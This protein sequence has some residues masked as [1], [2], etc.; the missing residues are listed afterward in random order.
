LTDL[1]ERVGLTLTEM[2]ARCGVAG[3]QGRKTVGDWEAGRATPRASRRAK[4]VDYL[5]YDLQLREDP[6]RFDEVWTILVEEWGWEPLNATERMQLLDAPTSAPLTITNV[7]V[8]TATA[9]PVIVTPEP[10]APPSDLLADPPLPEITL[11]AVVQPTGFPWLA[12]LATWRCW[13]LI[14]ILLLLLLVGCQVWWGREEARLPPL[15]ATEVIPS[16][17]APL[18]KVASEVLLTSTVTVAV[19]S[20]LLTNG[21]F[22]QSSNFTGW[23]L[24]E[25]CDYQITAEPTLAQS[26]DHYLTIRNRRPRC[27]SFY[28]DV[29]TRLEVGVTYRASIWLRSATGNVRR[30]RLALWALG[31]DREHQETSFAVS[32]TSWTCL[33]TTF[34]VKKPNHDHLKF[35]VYLDS[36]DGLDYHFDTAALRQGSASHCPNP[37]LAI[38]DLQLVQPSGQIYPGATVGVQALVKNVGSTALP[39]ETF[40]RY[41]VAEEENDRPF[42]PAA[43]RGMTIPPLAAGETASVAHVDLYLPINLPADRT[44]FVVAD[45]T[46]ANTP[47]DFSAGFDRSSHAFAVTPCAQGTLY[48]D[49]PTDH[50]AATEIQAWFDAGI[51]QSCR[52]N[53]EPF[54]NRPFCPDAVVQRWMMV[55]FLL[56][57]LEGSDYQPAAA[58]QGL[59]EDVPQEFEHAGALWIEALTTQRVNMHSDACPP[60]GEHRR[61]CPYDPLRRGDFVRVL[62]ELQRWDVSAVAG[63]RFADMPAG[64]IEARAAEYMWQQGHLPANDTDCPSNTG[65]P[66]FCPNAP[67]RRASAAVMMSRALGLIE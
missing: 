11:P 48:C 44:Y 41:W 17:E 16:V 2:A 64:T 37:Q 56:R 9:E 62:L 12:A 53:T 49:V 5:W 43:V 27:F 65:Y 34:V 26:G 61:F 46:A 35:E 40:I 6:V 28:Q 22:D 32:N 52:S 63:T 45:L 24:Y 55:F 15:S 50:W 4:F 10:Q 59:F 67:L 36:Y 51:S 14:A 31:A 3:N 1:R 57:R 29:F 25:A 39:Q 58:Y 8:E 47:D 54:L 23:N 60:R 42:D 66:R 38:A 18:I 30:G 7:G 13:S 21:G 33:E 19:S 20:L